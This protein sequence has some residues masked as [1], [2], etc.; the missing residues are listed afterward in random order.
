MS[1]RSTAVSNRIGDSSVGNDVQTT[2]GDVCLREIRNQIGG[3]R[4]RYWMMSRFWISHSPFTL[5]I[6]SW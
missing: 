5:T 4:L 1:R 2:R 6:V 3:A